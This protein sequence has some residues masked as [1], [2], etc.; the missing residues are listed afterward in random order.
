MIPRIAAFFLAGVVLLYLGLIGVGNWAA[1]EYDDFG[2]LAKEGWH[3]VWARFHW[4]PRPV[5]EPLFLIYG[6][7]V[8]ELRRPLI[9]PFLGLLWCAFLAAGLF[10]FWQS[11]RERD[12]EAGSAQLELLIALA[13][14]ASFVT[15]GG[16]AEAFYWPAGA[17]ECLLTVAATLLLFLQTAQGRLGSASGR[18][19]CSACLIAAAG[20]SEMGAGFVLVYAAAQVV[21]RIVFAKERRESEWRGPVAWWLVPTVVA[22]LVLV[23]LQAYRLRVSEHPTWYAPG[24]SSASLVM[25][26]LWEVSREVFG[27]STRADGR[28]IVNSRLVSEVL[29]AL[30]IA[31]CWSRM[32][33]RSKEVAWDMAALSAALLLSSVLT[34]AAAEIH[35][36]AVCC[37]RH[38]TVRRTWIFM[39]LAG[40]AIVFLGARWAERLHQRSVTVLAPLL[41]CAGVIVAWH[42]RPVLREYRN[43]GAIYRAMDENFQSGFNPQSDSMTFLSRPAGGIIYQEQVPPGVYE[44]SENTPQYVKYVLRFFNKRRMVVRPAGHPE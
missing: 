32:W 19:V 42:T 43:Y 11:R 41:L 38:E 26:G 31:L 35:F 22:M 9:L 21:K 13:L 8:N 12:S 16:M 3:E 28:L 36:H 14:M 5:S 7:A 17:V 40:I 6:W 15:G 34:I 10:T 2:R 23:A 29:L 4:S 44:L 1:D 39:G 24:T 18:R 20:S 37:S 33:K 27:V 25:I 30:G